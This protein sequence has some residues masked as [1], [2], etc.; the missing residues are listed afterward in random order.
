M[1]FTAY[2]SNV[3]CLFVWQNLNTLVRIVANRTTQVRMI[4]WNVRS[5]ALNVRPN[6]VCQVAVTR[7]ALGVKKRN[8]N[9]SN[10][11]NQIR[12]KS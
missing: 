12:F 3:R 9:K 5:A 11:G 7:Y 1:T 2:E 6:A 10:Y 8:K 4:L